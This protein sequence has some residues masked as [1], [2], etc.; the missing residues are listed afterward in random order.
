MYLEQLERYN[1]MAQKNQTRQNMPVAA[2]VNERNFPI[3]KN[4]LL[5]GIVCF[6]K[7]SMASQQLLPI[8]ESKLQN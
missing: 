2:E 4:R 8:E 7:C 6:K 3:V 5:D 1:Y